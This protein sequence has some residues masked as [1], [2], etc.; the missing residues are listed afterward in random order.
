[1]LCL[2][3]IFLKGQ[4]ENQN[5]ALYYKYITDEGIVF[6][7]YNIEKNKNILLDTD[8]ELQRG[9]INDINGGLPFFPRYYAVVVNG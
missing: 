1:M 9:I 3:L 2:Y 4:K 5:S 7:I 6:G 8:D